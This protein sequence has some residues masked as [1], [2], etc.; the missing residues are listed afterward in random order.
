VL[1]NASTLTVEL[2]VLGAGKLLGALGAVVA[3][4][5]GGAKRSSALGAQ[6]HARG[7]AGEDALGEH[8]VG[9]GRVEIWDAQLVSW[10]VVAARAELTKRTGAWPV[11]VRMVRPHGKCRRVCAVCTCPR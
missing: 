10:V 7:G 9:G 1:R 5:A 3:G 4:G 11:T 8:V 2:V 6:S